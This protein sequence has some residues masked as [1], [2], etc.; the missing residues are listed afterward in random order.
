MWISP[1]VGR[2]MVDIML[3]ALFSAPG[4]SHDANE[5]PFVDAQI[6]IGKRLVGHRGLVDFAQIAHI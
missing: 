2:S 1:D 3:A 5:F 4:W 6:D